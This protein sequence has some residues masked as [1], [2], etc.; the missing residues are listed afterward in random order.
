MAKWCNGATTTA[1]TF[2]P[3]T[4]EP[5][6]N[7]HTNTQIH[8]YVYAKGSRVKAIVISQRLAAVCGMQL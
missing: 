8:I 4:V 3:T 7:P 2:T 1:E 5:N 6:A